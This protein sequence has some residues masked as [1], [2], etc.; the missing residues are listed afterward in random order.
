[1]TKK[2]KRETEGLNLSFSLQI[3]SIFYGGKI[4]KNTWKYVLIT[5]LDYI[6]TFILFNKKLIQKKL[7]QNLNL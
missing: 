3:M 7:F 5:I 6:K 2:F 4:L 1:M